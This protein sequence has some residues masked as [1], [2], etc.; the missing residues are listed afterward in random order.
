MNNA[1]FGST[2]NL[3][4]LFIFALLP[5]SFSFQSC[6]SGMVPQDLY[7]LEQNMSLKAD[8]LSL[9]KRGGKNFTSV[10]D[11]IMNLKNRMNDLI[12]YE[13]DKGEKNIKTVKMLETMMDPNQNLL[14]GFLNRWETDGKLNGPFIKEAAKVVTK[15][16]DKIIKLENKKKKA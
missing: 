9:M 7:S 14:G 13:R 10:S 11:D 2:R 3:L 12:S 8:V 15:N 1:T 16:F 4:F 6:S 5:L